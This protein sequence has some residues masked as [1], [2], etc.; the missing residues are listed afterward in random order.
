MLLRIIP[1]NH[2]LLLLLLVCQLLL[3]TW[4]HVVHLLLLAK[5]AVGTGCIR[6]GGLLVGELLLL[7]GHVLLLILSPH[8]NVHLLVMIHGGGVVALTILL[9]ADLPGSSVVLV[10][11]LLLLSGWLGDVGVGLAPL[12]KLVL[13]AHSCGSVLELGSSYLLAHE[14]RLL[15]LLLV[16]I[17]MLWHLLVEV[18]MC[19]QSSA[20]C[21]NLLLLGVAIGEFHLFALSKGHRL[22]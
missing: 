15:L 9:T 2:L 16:L 3:A 12:V 10:A 6:M 17:L 11:L 8:L 13:V 22:L 4:L 1:V 7:V 20:V 19:V 18:L 5:V 14:L 21:L